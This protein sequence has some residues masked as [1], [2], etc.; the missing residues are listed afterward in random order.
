[1]NTDEYTLVLKEK[2]NSRFSEYA[3]F[4]PAIAD[5]LKL[6]LRYACLGIATLT[7]SQLS[8]CTADQW[9][10]FRGPGASG[11]ATNQ[12]LPDS[13]DVNTGDNIHWKTFIPGLGHAC[14]IVSR[15]RVFIVTADNGETDPELRLGLYGDIAPVEDDREHR[16]KLLCLSQTTGKILWERTLHRGV[17]AIKRHTKA[18]HANSTPATDGQR[19]VV[20]LGSEGLHCLD[21]SGNLLWKKDLGVLDS[22][23]FD[24]PAAQWEFGASP[25]IYNGS[26]FLQCDVQEN[27]FVA[28]LDI[29]NGHQL[30]RTPRTDVPTWSTPTIVPGASRTELVVNGFRHTSG[31][32]PAS[33][34]LL[35]NLAGGG[36]IPVP[37]PIFAHGLIFFSSAH[38]SNRPLYAI[39][40]GAAGDLTQSKDEPQ[41]EAIAWY[42]QREGIYLQTPIVY[43][44]HLYA[45]RNNGLLSCYEARSGKR[46]YRKRLGSG[47]SGFTASPVAA[48][49]KLYFTRE[50]GTMFVVE[51]GPKFKLVATNE[52]NESC[53][54]TPAI[55]GRLLI[56]RSTKH[57][58]AIGNPPPEL[59]ATHAFGAAEQCP[60]YTPGGWFPASSTPNCVRRRNI[61]QP[62]CRQ[63]R[64]RTKCKVR[65]PIPQKPGT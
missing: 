59:A 16:W 41:N 48:D 31:Y 51:H 15:G 36:D 12:N 26:V 27:S 53:M 62:K 40:P 50:D 14:P 65:C 8:K 23:Y 45:C 9:P 5:S 63:V 54:A 18:T 19:I 11:I 2:M 35:W 32:D 33:G 7:S 38:G 34:K 30:W 29:C 47:K 58:Y 64:R 49:G 17:P 28:A 60:A 55:A 37:T 52:M 24:A 25:I 22:G 56:V 20:C 61:C 1:L 3:V 10:Q 46:L 4:V 39:R 44:D 42:E 13:W 43:G 57:V 21:F 6:F